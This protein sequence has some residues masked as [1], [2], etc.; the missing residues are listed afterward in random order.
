M[1][2]VLPDIS[3]ENRLLNRANLNDQ[4]AISEI[5]ETFFSPIYQFIRLRVDDKLFAEDIASDVFTKLIDT[6]GTRQ[7]PR[8]SLRG[9][10]FRVARNEIHRH[11]GKSRRFSSETLDEWLPAESDSDL[12]L[13]FIRAMNVERARQALQMIGPD[14]QEVLIL[15]FGEGLSLQETADIMGKST[16][17]VK[18]LQ[19][20]AVNALRR[21]L[22]EMRLAEYG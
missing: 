13:D 17:A 1:G 16:S 6:I 22:G 5:Y 8:H 2:F 10:L 9:W 11:Y 21:I 19:F 18:S 7:G 20:R 3:T 12:E 15:R 4:E 14:Q